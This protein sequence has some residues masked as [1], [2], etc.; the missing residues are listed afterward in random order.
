[1]ARSRFRIQGYLPDNRT[2]TEWFDAED[3]PEAK[4]FFISSEARL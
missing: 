2:M 1:M 3:A 4:K